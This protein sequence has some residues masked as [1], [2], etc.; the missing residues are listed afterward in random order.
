VRLVA[1]RTAR[2]SGIDQLAERGGYR[3]RITA[4]GECCEA[5]L[6]NP[7]GGLV[8]G[9]RITFDVRAAAHAH[10]TVSSAAA[11]R[12]YR[13]DDLV[14]RVDCRLLAEPGARL[15]WLPQ[16]TLAYDGCRFQR[17]LEVEAA[18]DA[19]VTVLELLAL[20]RPASGG[21]LERVSLADHWRI[22]REGRLVLADSLRLTD[23]T[24]TRA[25]HPATLGGAGAIATLVHVSP[26]ALARLDRVRELL[27]D[28]PASGASV[29]DGVLVARWLAPESMRLVAHLQTF[30][31]EFRGRP[32]PRGW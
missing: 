20:G 12:I 31:A 23:A 2:G 32:G 28:V 27:A 7:A 19:H 10:L 4:E 18:A 25:T 14:A 22:R 11:E 16:Q 13:S 5:Y 26:D 6:L 1:S 24:M 8:G 30:L 3:A 17:C 21:P 15:E 9:D 29:V